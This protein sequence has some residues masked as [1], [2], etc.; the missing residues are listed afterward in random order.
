MVIDGRV[1]SSEADEAI[2]HESLIIPAYVCSQRPAN[3]LCLGGANGGVLHRLCALPGVER[4]VQIDVDEEL[5]RTSV[6][7][8]PHMHR[9]APGDR[10]CDVMFGEPRAILRTVD[11]PFDLILADLP[12]CVDGSHTPSLFT[13]EFYGELRGLLGVAGTFATQAGPANPLDPTFFASVLRTAGSV[14]QHA[15]PYVI[16]VPAFGVPW[17]FVVAS[18]AIDPAGVSEQVVTDRLGQIASDWAHAYDWQTHQHM[19]AL[20]LTLRRGLARSGR[21]IRDDEPLFQA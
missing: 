10:R 2:Y 9:A 3:V 5:H 16:T 8:L 13:A 17:G 11:A 21:V 4:M 1:Q 19:F 18:D 12:D 6:D 20:P 15:T 7:L 14:F